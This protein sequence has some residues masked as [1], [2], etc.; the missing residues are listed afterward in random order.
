MNVDKIEAL[1]L[2]G[3]VDDAKALAHSF[4]KDRSR[5][6]FAE[7]CRA[8]ILFALHGIDATYLLDVAYDLADDYEGTERRIET[9]WVNKVRRDVLAFLSVD[10]TVKLFLHMRRSRWQVASGSSMFIGWGDG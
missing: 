2:E 6:D 8:A 5:E 9:R 7:F 10:K 1:L 4:T 3:R